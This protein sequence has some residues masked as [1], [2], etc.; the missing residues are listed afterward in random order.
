MADENEKT[1][2]EKKSKAKNPLIMIIAIAIV[3]T[4]FAGGI[5]FLIVKKMLGEAETGQTKV[6]VANRVGPLHPL[7]DEFLVNLCDE[8]ANHYIKAKVALEVANEETLAE[9]VER[10]PQIRDEIISILRTKK[11][12]DMQKPDGMLKLKEEIRKKCN[13]N[14]TKG[15]ILMVYFTDFVMQ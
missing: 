13:E 4:I 9:V 2:E 1:S 12:E 5:S 6:V 8:E 7:E 14:L 3:A 15:T 11:T 10:T